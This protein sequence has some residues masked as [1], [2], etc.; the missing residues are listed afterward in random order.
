MGFAH[1]WR[2]IARLA[3]ARNVHRSAGMKAANPYDMHDHS[4]A[5]WLAP[6]IA[7]FVLTIFAALAM[8]VY[9]HLF[10]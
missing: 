10:G 1:G 7:I 4:G 6:F 5:R 9:P 8:L 3:A 2:S